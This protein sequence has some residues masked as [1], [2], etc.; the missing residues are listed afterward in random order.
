ME[1]LEILQNSFE[2]RNGHWPV[3]RKVIGFE[4]FDGI[5]VLSEFEKIIS[6]PKNWKTIVENKDLFNNWVAPHAIL[7]FGKKW[8]DSVKFKS[9]LTIGVSFSLFS[10]EEKQEAMKKGISIEKSV[11][12]RAIITRIVVK[13]A[14]S[15]KKYL[16]G[17]GLGAIRSPKNYIIRALENDVV[18]KI[19]KDLGYKQKAV[20]VCP[21][22]FSEKDNRYKRSI[23]LNHGSSIYECSRC[24]TMAN[25]L[26]LQLNKNK[27]NNTYSKEEE[28]KYLLFKK[29]SNIVGISC[30]CPNNNCHGKFIPI[31]FA[32]IDGKEL[33]AILIGY[34]FL[35]GTQTYKFP[36]AKL[37]D[38]DIKCPFCKIEFTPRKA[39]DGKSGYKNN[40]GFF[41]GIPTTFIWE[42]VEKMELDIPIHELEKARGNSGRMAKDYLVNSYKNVDEDII[43][44]QKLNLIIGEL[45]LK[46]FDLQKKNIRELTSWYFYSAVIKWIKK[47]PR[48]SYNYFFEWRS[49]KR[50]LTLSEKQKGDL[51]TKNYTKVILGQEVAIHKSLFQVWIDLLEENIN[52]FN[53]INPKIV[54]VSDLKWF[55][56]E[57]KFSGGP[58]ST[59]TDVVCDRKI[60]NKSPIVGPN[61]TRIA[62]VYSVYKIVDGQA[63]KSINYV[64]SIIYSDWQT[65]E[66]GKDFCDGDV[67]EI[68]ALMMSG[69]TTH[70]PIQ[71]IL[72]LRSLILHDFVVKILEEVETGNTDV[73][74]W[75][76]WKINV[77]SARKKLNLDKE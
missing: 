15:L 60:T 44:R 57:P 41:T 29:F 50:E 24:T 13:T 56:R 26:L 7:L 54:S 34:K 65:I 12:G 23:L 33:E 1:D 16:G 71:R 31:N 5:G 9:S 27:L 52:D 66:F 14:H 48:D 32:N 43:I 6:D 63:D 77:D 59:F 49:D 10:K 17:D 64:N 25:N 36:H 47:Y 74:F 37:M 22:C 75:K 73:S 3:P 40:G 19:G 42:K 55:C 70:T 61:G 20:C 21:K 51:G 38:V 35:F 39:I 62:K 8:F 68:E 76:N 69:H 18:Q 45:T 2:L 11:S 30:V 58:M 72:R 53:T 4:M 46:L 28:N 67:V